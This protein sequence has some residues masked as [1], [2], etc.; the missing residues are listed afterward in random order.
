VP[1]VSIPPIH[2]PFDARR[3][4]REARPALSIAPPPREQGWG[5]EDQGKQGV[6][7]VEA[8]IGRWSGARLAVVAMDGPGVK[9]GRERGPNV[10]SM[11][12]VVSGLYVSEVSSP[13]RA[14]IRSPAICPP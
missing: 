2:P 11:S 14:A 12:R 1:T 8:R 10:P 9:A 7:G 4:P 6:G 5:G 3:R 13:A